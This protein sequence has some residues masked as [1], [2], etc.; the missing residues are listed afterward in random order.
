MQG[1]A[2]GENEVQESIPAQLGRR[3]RQ[4]VD[5]AKA[6]A[7][8]SLADLET[9]TNGI[10]D[11]AQG[12]LDGFVEKVYS[13]KQKVITGIDTAIGAI[14][15]PLLGLAPLLRETANAGM[16][17]VFGVAETIPATVQEQIK[18]VKD[19]LIEQ[20]QTQVDKIAET[21]V[22]TVSSDA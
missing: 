11:K 14:E 15:T 20:V 7:E 16:Q 2:S 6:Q 10:I 8:K 18:G 12:A 21:A 5:S 4:S 3:A 17:A 22:S 1:S 13:T 19:P 9:K